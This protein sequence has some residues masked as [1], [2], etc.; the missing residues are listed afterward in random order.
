MYHCN[1][2]F[3]VIGDGN[4]LPAVLKKTEPLEHFTHKIVTSAK[5]DETFMRKADVIFADTCGADAADILRF[6]NSHKKD[7]AELILILDKGQIDSLAEEELSTVTDIWTAPLSDKEMQFR[8]L[9]WQETCKMSKDYWQTQAYLDTTINSVPHMV[10]YK[11]KE[12]AHMKVN[13]FF[14]KTVNKTMEQIRGRGHYYI[15]DIEPEEYAKGEFICMESEYEVMEK[16][17]TCIFDEDVKIGD[18]MRK[19]K[20][21]KSPLFDLDGSVMGTVGVALDVTELTMYQQ[22]LLKNA[23]TDAL[24]EL[25]NRRYVYEYINDMEDSPVT[26]FLIDLDNFKT[27]NDVY[28]HQEGDRALVLTAKVLREC[29]AGSLIARIGGDEFLI[30]MLGDHSMQEMEEIRKKIEAQLDDAFHKIETLQNISASV[31]AAHADKGKENFDMLVGK[32]DTLMYKEKEG[33]KRHS[34]HVA[35]EQKRT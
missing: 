15:W 7:S 33:K 1:V 16:R 26:I 9:R 28:G 25:Y 19:L 27:T 11:D 12:G 2:C 10:W 14:C 17:E 29:M 8:V 6:V 24:T 23:N 13:D 31:G 3:Y 35:G 22:M 20:T 5:P 4:G 21:Y 18:E 32:A 34:R 30:V